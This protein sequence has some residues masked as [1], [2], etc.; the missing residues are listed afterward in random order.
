MGIHVLTT[1]VSRPSFLLSKVVSKVG[2]LTLGKRLPRVLSCRIRFEFD[3]VGG[4][5]SSVDS[6]TIQSYGHSTWKA[7]TRTLGEGGELMDRWSIKLYQATDEVLWTVKLNAV[8][9]LFSLAGGILLG[10]GPATSAACELSRRRASGESFQLWPAFAGAFRRQFV[11]GS[12]LLIPPLAVAALLFGNYLYFMALG[13]VASVPRLVTFAA[14]FALVPIVSFLLPLSVH[15]DL[16]VRACLIKA[17]LLAITRPA[18]SVVLLFTFLAVVYVAQTFP[19]LG[20]VLAVGGWIRLD[21]WLCL[22]FF[23]ENAARLQAKGIS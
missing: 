15:Y 17:S 10:I 9:A 2:F 23:E 12:L 4:G 16:R 8:W 11:R 6:E 3:N 21:T 13:P 14:L 7:L 19:F 5:D 22:R 18:S 1:M 20:L